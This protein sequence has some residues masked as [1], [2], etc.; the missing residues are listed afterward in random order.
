MNLTLAASKENKDYILNHYGL[1]LEK[2]TSKK[3]L[4]K[5]FNKHLK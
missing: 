5:Q 1:T 3:T 2:V 4:V